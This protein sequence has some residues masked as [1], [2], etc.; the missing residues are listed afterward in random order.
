MCNVYEP[1]TEQYLRSEW[2]DYEEALRPYK[3]RIGP[4]D[5]GPFLTAKRMVAGQWGMI[6]LGSPTR[7]QRAKPKKEGRLG[8]L[9][10]TNNARTD[11]MTT[12]PTYRDAWRNGQRCLIPAFSY[13]EPYYPDGVNNIWWRFRRADGDPWLLAGLWSEWTDHATGEVV[14]NITMLTLNCDAHPLLKQ[15]HKPERDRERNVLPPTKQ[16]KRTVM[17]IECSDWELW[18]NG[19]TDDALSL[20][21]LPPLAVFAHGAV[22]PAKQIDIPIE[23]T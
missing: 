10:M 7:I 9:L 1:A 15:F 4:R 16:D 17:P 5:D 18:L 3:D 14:P 22:D 20:I 11:R 13:D 8:E 21:Q 2:R 23:A 6:R 19:S 12:A